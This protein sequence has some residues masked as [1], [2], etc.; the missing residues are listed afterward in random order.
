[1]LETLQN[2]LKDAMK[3][4]E[5]AVMKGLRNIIAA[6]SA[7]EKA[8]KDKKYRKSANYELTLIEKGM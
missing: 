1:M 6:K 8:S 7:F 5:K 2:E 4:G 3:L